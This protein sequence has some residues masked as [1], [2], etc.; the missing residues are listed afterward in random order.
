MVAIPM[1]TNFSIIPIP[2]ADQEDA[3]RFYTEK[4]DFEKRT[5]I[6][7]GPGMRLLTVAPRGQFKPVFALAKP[8]TPAVYREC[9]R[10]QDDLWVIG[11]EDCHSVYEALSK[12]GVRFVS[13]PTRYTRS[14]EAVFADPYGNLFSLLERLPDVPAVYRIDA[15]A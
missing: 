10:S 12:R 3:L 2:V 5:D 9:I 6:T 15:A 4:L 8:D 11:T 13:P 1:K 14:I 7:F